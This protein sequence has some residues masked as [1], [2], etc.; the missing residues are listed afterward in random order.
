MKLGRAVIDAG[1]DVIL[2]HHPHVLQGIEDYKG[3]L[4]AYSLGNFVFDLADDS[5]RQSAYRDCLLARRYGVRFER[6]DNRVSESMILEI[7]LNRKGLINYKVHPILIGNDFRPVP[8]HGEE[9]SRLRE[10][11]K[12]LGKNIGNNSLALNRVLRKVEADSLQTYLK[13]KSLSYYFR[14]LKKLRLSHVVILP[15]LVKAKLRK[16][17]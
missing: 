2:G 1:A 9:G 3:K 12:E 10:R 13:K 17:K 7:V 6:N 5:I 15:A 8:L 11:I 14:N 4:I 16:G